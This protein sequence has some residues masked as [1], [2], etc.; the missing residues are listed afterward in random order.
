MRVERPLRLPC[1]RAADDVHVGEE[2]LLG[3]TERHRCHEE[4]VEGR[5]REKC[6]N[7]LDRRESLFFGCYEGPLVRGVRD[8][9]GD[10]AKIQVERAIDVNEQVVALEGI[11]EEGRDDI[12]DGSIRIP[13]KLAE[14]YR[15]ERRLGLGN[16]LCNVREEA[17]YGLGKKIGAPP[18]VPQER[19]KGSPF[20]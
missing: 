14:R 3:D 2:G 12:E 11:V 5:T 13:E 15:K 16:L 1:P 20:S 19:V 17:A 18:F 4:I 10:A 7:R 6:R 9:P 8:E